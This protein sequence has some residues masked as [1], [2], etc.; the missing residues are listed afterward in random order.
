MEYKKRKLGLFVLS[1]LCLLFVGRSSFAIDDGTL[2]DECTYA[3][4]DGW[5]CIT[6]GRG[7]DQRFCWCT[8]CEDLSAAGAVYQVGQDQYL[9]G[10]VPNGASLSKKC[11]PFPVQIKT[12]DLNDTR[13][14]TT[15]KAAIDEI[16]RLKGLR[17][18]QKGQTIAPTEVKTPIQKTP[19]FLQK[20]TTLT[21]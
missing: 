8:F 15:D 6:W 13:V 21:K 11:V 7:D 18:P 4:C 14:E 20:T 17:A 3:G 5:D 16:L 10:A 2:V 1:L 9:C 19:T 12:L